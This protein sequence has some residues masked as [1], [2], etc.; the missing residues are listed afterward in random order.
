MKKKQKGEF[1]I[2]SA[3]LLAI[4]LSVVAGGELTASER[5]ADLKSKNEAKVTEVS[6]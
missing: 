1:L 3:I 2:G 4:F 5:E 6:K